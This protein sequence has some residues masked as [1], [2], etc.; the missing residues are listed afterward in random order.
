MEPKKDEWDYPLPLIVILCVLCLP[1]VAYM[2]AKEKVL[3][4]LARRR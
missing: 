2:W 3:A 4:A 1:V